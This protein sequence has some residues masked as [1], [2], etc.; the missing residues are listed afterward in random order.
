MIITSD[1]HIHSESSYDASLTL[2]TIAE[3]AKK[4]GVKKIGITDHLNY[5]DKSFINDLK[6]SSESVKEFKKKDIDIILGVELTPIGKPEFDYILKT[7][8]RD[9]FIPPIT[10]D[11]YPIELA[12]TKEELISLGVRYAVGAS[13]WRVDGPKAKENS[14]NVDG[15]IKEWYRQQLWLALDERV[16]ILGHPWYNGKGL[17]YEDFSMIPRS[18]N[19][20]IA[21]AL[22]ENKK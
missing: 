1:W 18:M 12:M 10:D 4:C 11:V 7:G 6:K 3:N 2:E 20:E 5:N 13:H 19:M 15:C 22:L 8:I 14:D 9:G 17:W 16:T 21:A